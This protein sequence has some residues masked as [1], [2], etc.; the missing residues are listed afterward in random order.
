MYVF[1]R[2]RANKTKQKRDPFYTDLKRLFYVS[3]HSLASYVVI[4]PALDEE[5]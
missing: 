1:S 4:S 2:C 3:N 5:I